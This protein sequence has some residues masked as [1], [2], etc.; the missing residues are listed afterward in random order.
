MDDERIKQ[1]TQEVLADLV[2]PAEA[3]LSGAT[4]LEAR[5]ASLESEVRGLRGGAP[6]GRAGPLVAA[7]GG[8]SAVRPPPPRFP[9]FPPGPGPPP[10]VMEAHHPCLPS[11]ACL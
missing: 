3:D 9:P 6:A 1:L 8:V 11:G 5:L 7:A 10:R 2:R 4:D